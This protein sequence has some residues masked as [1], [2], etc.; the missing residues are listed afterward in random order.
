MIVGA[1]LAFPDD[2]QER[3]AKRFAQRADELLECNGLRLATGDLCLVSSLCGGQIQLKAVVVHD[4]S[5]TGRHRT[6]CTVLCVREALGEALTLN[7]SN[8][9]IASGLVHSL[10]VLASYSER[11][12]MVCRLIEALRYFQHFFNKV[13]IFHRC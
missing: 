6:T 8:L 12:E 9:T 7:L 1:L 4:V 11:S 2:R 10:L 13:W 5:T 3:V